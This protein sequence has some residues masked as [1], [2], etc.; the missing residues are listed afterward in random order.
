MMVKNFK[1]C[2]KCKVEKPL[3][4]FYGMSSIKDGKRPS[5][6]A[7][8]KKVKRTYATKHPVMERCKRMGRSIISRTVTDINN[9]KNKTYKENNIKSHIGNSGIEI[10]E[11]L[12][13]N[14]Y[15]EI[16]RMIEMGETPTVDRIDSA[17]G[18]EKDN[19]QILSFKDN[20]LDGLSNAVK[21]TSKAIKVRFPDGSHRIFK[22]VSEASR[23]L[24]L[25]RETI[26]RNR[27]NGTP[28]RF[29][30]LFETAR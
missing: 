5:C 2:S 6:K 14:F 9:P 21:K 13:A 22:S 11:Y 28:T 26:I 10:A 20:S 30:L 7:C 4:E 15:D 3:D 12:Y 29:G 1:Q 19:I 23:E 25:K 27:D 16:E 17:R 24:K 18:Y 8:D